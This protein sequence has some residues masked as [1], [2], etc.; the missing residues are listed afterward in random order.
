MQGLG[1]G[2]FLRTRTLPGTVKAFDFVCAT[3]T[4]DLGKLAS[5]VAVNLLLHSACA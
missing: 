5:R 4:V 1:T 3:P 2:N